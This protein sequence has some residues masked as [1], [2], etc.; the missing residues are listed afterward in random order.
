MDWRRR[1]LEL[2]S[3]KKPRQFLFLL[4]LERREIIAGD[5]AKPFAQPMNA[6][7]R[8]AVTDSHLLGD[9]AQRHVSTN[10]DQ[11]GHLLGGEL[12]G[13]TLRQTTE[14]R[15]ACLS[16]TSISHRQRVIGYALGDY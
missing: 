2:R 4:G 3:A 1:Q 8:G 15:L 12:A 16:L 10:A 11:H 6:H 9:L 14:G 5:T 7:S 13:D